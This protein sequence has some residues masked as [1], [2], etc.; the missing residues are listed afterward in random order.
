MARARPEIRRALL[1]LVGGAA[2]A[3]CGGAG[4][5]SAARPAET[6]GAGTW[7]AAWTAD[8]SDA[9][10]HGVVTQTQRTILTPELG[11]D[12]LRVHLSNRLGLAPVTFQ[13]ASVGLRQGGA[14]AGLV[15][16]SR[17]P[18]TFSGAASVTIPT[19]AE[20]T[21]DPVALGVKAGDDVAVS[22]YD[23][24]A[25][26]PATEHLVGQQTS[27]FTPPG[28][29]DHTGEDTGAAF[30]LP[31]TARYFVTSVEVR[32]PAPVGTVVAFGDSITDGFGGPPDQNDRYPD[33]LARR[34]AAEAPGR[35]LGVVDA[36]IG[37][38]RVLSDARPQ[39]GGAS[40]LD[41]LDTDVIGQPGATD[42]I[43]LEGV[44]DLGARA[45]ADQVTGGL[46]Q[47]VTRLH[48]AGLRVQ[49]GTLTPFGR[50]GPPSP[51][52][53]AAEASRT[54]VNRWIRGGGA[55]ADATIDF[56]AA[57]RDPADRTRLDPRYDSGDHLHPNGAGRQAMA[58]AVDLAGL[59][60]ATCHPA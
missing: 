4:A 24:G 43:V 50:P 1:V 10:N 21:S 5:G 22:L 54:A 59:A 35:H 49:L 58:R 29:G 3:G 37:G 33:V 25:S 18:V 26:G 14:G 32:S 40:G 16:G 15:P 2:L 36:G 28:S 20:V 23:A 38:N 56:D 17:R 19:G 42:V 39:M 13:A 41:R 46:E 8:P 52:V 55:R 7:V 53:A 12:A 60:P 11:G 51:T 30:T 47:L 6:C 48:A 9:V 34:L 31:S 57:V 44:N 27:Y 45:S